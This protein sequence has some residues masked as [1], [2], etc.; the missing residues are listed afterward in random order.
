MLGSILELATRPKL[1]IL[2]IQIYQ[3]WRDDNIPPACQHWTPML[4]F[5]R[6]GVKNENGLHPWR[7][8]YKNE[9]LIKESACGQL[10]CDSKCNMSA[11][12]GKDCPTMIDII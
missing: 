1:V 7:I 3:F 5:A 11:I 6:R 9:T 2:E 10:N 4:K 8:A 12:S